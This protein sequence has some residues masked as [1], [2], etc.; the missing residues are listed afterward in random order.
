V[1]QQPISDLKHPFEVCKSHRHT[2]P[3]GLLW[4]TDQ[5]VAEDAA[6][7]TRTQEMKF[8]TPGGIRIL[9]PSKQAAAEQ[10]LRPHYHRNRQ[11]ICYSA[12]YFTIA[13]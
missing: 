1:T 8:L 13:R 5:L 11:E 4:T 7:T 9:D 10:R 6:Y 2:Q 12:K 3:V